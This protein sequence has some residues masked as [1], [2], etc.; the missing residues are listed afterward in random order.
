M[1]VQNSPKKQLGKK[2]FWNSIFSF[3]YKARAGASPAWQKQ[4]KFCM[5]ASSKYCST[6][7]PA[8]ALKISAG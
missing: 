1:E 6:E 2:D 7:A 4:Q 5:F 8:Q 3:V